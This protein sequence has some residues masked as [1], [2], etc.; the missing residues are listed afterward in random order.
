MRKVL[1]LGAYGNVGQVVTI[2][3]ISS[4]FFV[5]IGGRNENKIENFINK[6]K[7]NNVEKVLFDISD[8]KS[9]LNIFS[10]YDLIINCLEY[11]FNQTILDS[12]I[13]SG[14]NYVDLGDDYLGIKVSR[15]KDGLAKESGIFACI[16]AGSAPG[17]VNVLTKYAIRDISE[18][19]TIT[20][21]F[22]D[23]IKNAPEKM[24]PFNFQTVVEEITGDALLFENGKY[25]FVKGSSKK[26]DADFCNVSSLNQC[27][28]PG[29]LVT[30]HDEQF[31]LPDYLSDKGIKNFYFVM[32]HSDNVIKLVESLNEFGFLSKEKINIKGVE[33]SPFDFCNEIMSNFAPQNFK[34]EDKESLFIKIDNLVVEIVNYSVDGVPAGVM[35]TGIGCSLIAQDILNNSYTPGVKHPEDFVNE[36][37]FI[38]ELKKRNF[39][40]YIDGKII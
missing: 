25:S 27:L 38:T 2:D 9:L 3:L 35:N 8:E 19:N 28:L 23:E 29:S 40:I 30:N 31:S 15:S 16:G 39:E 12:C 33:I 7:S 14:K 20:I 11:T 26:I 1:V 4:G 6:L 13:K 34:V 32:K 36:D 10:N 21:S 24:L 18:I 22:A 37:W 5:G 17:I